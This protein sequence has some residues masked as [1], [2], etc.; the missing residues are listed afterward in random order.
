MSVPLS[1]MWTVARHVV[2][3]RLRGNKRYPLVVMLEPLFACNLS[4]AGCG[5]I[6]YPAHVLKRRLTPAQCFAAVEEA[7]API[8]SIPG[9][10]PLLHPEIDQIV[11]GLVERKKYV[12]MCTNALL[13]E[14]KLDLFR[15]S[16]YLSFSVHMDGPREEHDHSVCRF[17]TYDKAARAIQAAV[18]RG[19]R[20]TTNT[21]LFD[22]ADA[23]R[24]REFFDAMMNLGV[25][26]MM[27]SPGYHYPK[28]PDQ[29]S[30]LERQKT[31]DLFRQV[32]ARPKRRWKFNQ[33]PL[34][35]RF[36][37]GADDYECSPWGSPTYNI[38]GWQK[39][40]YLIQDGYAKTYQELME[41]THW[42]EYG[43]PERNSKCAHCMVHSGFEPA[44]VDRTFTTLSGFVRTAWSTLTGRF[45]R[46]RETPPMAIRPLEPAVVI[47][48]E[49]LHR[50]KAS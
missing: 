41:S 2:S 38:F 35:I 29:Q 37:M 32:F 23:T 17:G 9:G 45:A 44:A 39:P 4:C 16:K 31:R 22:G 13:L 30:F 10:E 3:N 5:K 15:P 46:S 43:A 18:K 28:A 36:L 14:E 33:T 25:E 1:Q 20:V 24:I 27:V 7:G 12:Y 49:S 11:A 48:I 47:P 8:V 34:F 6:Q 50:R 21:T 26:G 40:C 19:F 42:E